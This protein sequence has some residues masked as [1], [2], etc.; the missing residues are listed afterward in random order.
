M[1]MCNV[2]G[3][4]MSQQR[5]ITQICS[6]PQLFRQPFLQQLIDL[7]FHIFDLFGKMLT[8]KAFQLAI[9]D[10]CGTSESRF[11]SILLQNFI[12]QNPQICIRIYTFFSLLTFKM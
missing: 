3:V 6:P 9:V 2:K 7:V 5:I 11:T 1:T 12:L 8:L 4:V 10:F